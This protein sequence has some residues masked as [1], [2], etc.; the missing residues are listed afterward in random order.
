MSNDQQPKSTVVVSSNGGMFG[1]ANRT[2]SALS[3]TPV[4]LVMVLLNVA[5]IGAAA[6]YLR[7]QQDHAFTLVDKIFDR[8]LPEHLKPPSP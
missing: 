1:A 4:L 3:G 2:I 6:Y 7:S 8:C 5:F